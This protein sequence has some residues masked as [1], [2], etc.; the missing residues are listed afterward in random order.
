MIA[1]V[2]L[3][4]DAISELNE[5]RVV[6]IDALMKY[7]FNPLEPRDWHGRW[8]GEGSEGM[9]V[10]VSARG[11]SA[12]TTGDQWYSRLGAPTEL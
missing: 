10:S 3:R 4:V 12:A 9:A 1:A 8:A 5:V 6:R 11:P 2:Q 7:N